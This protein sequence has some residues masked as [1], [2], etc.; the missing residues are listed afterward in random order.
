[1]N[2]FD[3]DSGS[4]THDDQTNGVND[5]DSVQDPNEVLASLVGEGKKFRSVE[6]LAQGKVRADA[7][8]AQLI[9]EKRKLE[10][11]LAE[12][13]KLEDFMTEF[14]SLKTSDGNPSNGYGDLRATE[15]NP[16]TN[17]TLDAQ[18]LTAQILE[19]LEQKNRVD[20]ETRNVNHVKE[21][22]NKAYGPG[23]KNVLK[24]YADSMGMDPETVDRWA[25]VNPTAVVKSV[26][27]TVRTNSTPA[28]TPPSNSRVVIPGGSPASNGTGE[29]S[30]YSDFM[31]IKQRD[32]NLY[33]S[34]EMQVKLHDAAVKYGDA[35]FNS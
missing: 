6:Q 13:K 25:K 30:R 23:W 3:Q 34:R 9:E 14:K 33:R 28:V 18:A 26:T 22:L 8:I 11:A 35:F 1:M 12:Q 32:P 16:N 15:Q 5:L 17:G 2:I 24:Q 27:Q 10:E 7:F 31:K 4:D 21:E 29:L 20:V 19:A